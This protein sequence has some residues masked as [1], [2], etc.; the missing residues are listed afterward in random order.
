MTSQTTWI[1][2]TP[3]RVLVSFDFTPPE[4]RADV[5]HRIRVEEMTTCWDFISAA[6]S[7]EPLAWHFRCLGGE[8]LRRLTE[9]TAMAVR[10]AHPTDPRS[11]LEEN[12]LSA[13]EHDDLYGWHAWVGCEGEEGL[14]AFIGRVKD[15]LAQPIDWSERKEFHR[16]IT[17][18]REAALGLLGTLN[19]RLLKALGVRIV[20]AQEMDPQDDRH[21]AWQFGELVKDEEEANDI[22]RR[23][24]LDLRFRRLREET[25]VVE[26]AG[27][28]AR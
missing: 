21:P 8:E 7:C 28:A 2:V 16:L 3:E 22:A 23:L 9:P 14:P 12:I 20:E 26:G 6:E 17:N 27:H 18:E 24:G 19:W 11:R 25:L 5:Y 13:L 4:I 15:W 10:R 1:D